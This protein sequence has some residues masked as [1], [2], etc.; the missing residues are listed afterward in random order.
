MA[1]LHPARYQAPAP[2]TPVR[3]DL[4]RTVQ[5]PV[6]DSRELWGLGQAERLQPDDVAPSV[7][8]GY[9]QASDA[10]L[11]EQRRRIERE[12]YRRRLRQAAQVLDGAPRRWPWVLLLVVV[13][14][15]VLLGRV[16]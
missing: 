4:V 15:L 14:V 10:V 8:R 7:V 3:Y 9:T 11:R 12:Q 5:G 6:H 2:P 16:L 13:A 1:T